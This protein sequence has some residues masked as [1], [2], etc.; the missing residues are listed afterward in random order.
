[1]ALVDDRSFLLPYNHLILGVGR[2]GAGTGT[3]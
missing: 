2:V 3:G 1:V